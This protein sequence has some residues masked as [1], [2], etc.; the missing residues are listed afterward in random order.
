MHLIRRKPMHA[1]LV[2][3]VRS[4]QAPC[5]ELFQPQD[6]AERFMADVIRRFH[7]DPPGLFTPIALR[8]AVTSKGARVVLEAARQGRARRVGAR[9]TLI[10]WNIDEVSVRFHHC[11]TAQA[12]RAEIGKE[13]QEDMGECLDGLDD[14]E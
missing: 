12:L 1:H 4:P 14:D 9:W 8:R 6:A 5:A 13:F 2:L 10:V 7:N 11:S 3:T